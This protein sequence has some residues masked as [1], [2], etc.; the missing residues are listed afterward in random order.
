MKS[1]LQ[2][3]HDVQEE[4]EWEPSVD[5]AHIGVAANAGVVTLTGTVP[6]F[7]QKSKAENI[8]KSVSGVKA[9]ANDIEVHLAGSGQHNDTD[10]ATAALTAIK[11]H[12]SIPID[13]VKVSVRNG[14]ITLEGNL[15]WQYQRDSAESAVC[16][17]LGVKGVTNSITLVA[18]PQSKDVR[19]RIETAYK[20]S[21][22]VDAANVSVDVHD[23]TIVLK[24]NV[25][26]WSERSEA[27]RVAWAAPGAAT[28]DNRIT[29]GA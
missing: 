28:V 29:V 24:G 11:W 15:D 16:N 26:S 4:L 18:K 21:A 19:S 5:A 17:L 20:R 6:H 1:E 22:E 9:I 8:A 3:Q 23:S 25:S 7:S 13:K 10:I 27:E 14:W 12:Y 2:L